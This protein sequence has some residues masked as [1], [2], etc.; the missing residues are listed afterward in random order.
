VNI[1]LPCDEADRL[2]DWLQDSD[3]EYW[4][5]PLAG[6][7]DQVKGHYKYGCTIS[8]DGKQLYGRVI[9]FPYDDDKP[10]SAMVRVSHVL[11]NAPKKTEI[12]LSMLS[13]PIA[14]NFDGKSVVTFAGCDDR[15]IRYRLT[16][17]DVTSGHFSATRID[18]SEQ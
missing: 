5:T 17:F 8:C 2:F 7:A 1:R 11:T 12:A 9:T 6:I 3:I 16:S 18:E 13:T 4:N 15:P 10:I 14:A